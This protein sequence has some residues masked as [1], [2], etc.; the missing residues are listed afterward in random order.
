M[1][2]ASRNILTPNLVVFWLCSTQKTK[3]GT[4]RVLQRSIPIWTWFL[5][6][7]RK[8]FLFLA[9]QTH[10]PPFPLGIKN[11][12]SGYNHYLTLPTNICTTTW[13]LYCS[14]LFAWVRN[15]IFWILQIV[16]FFNLERMVGN[17]PPSSY[18]SNKSIINCKIKLKSSFWS[19]HSISISFLRYL[20]V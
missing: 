9:Y 3:P 17:E 4:T 11:P 16:W 2:K 1:Y 10:Q 6:I 18:I 15:P 5:Q 12:N 19:P 7:Y 14:T 13:Q 8:V 20:W